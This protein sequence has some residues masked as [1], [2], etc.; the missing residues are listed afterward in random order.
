MHEEGRLGLVGL[1]HRLA[2]DDPKARA[3]SGFY[4]ALHSGVLM[5]WL[6]DPNAPHGRR[7]HRGRAA[8]GGSRP[9]RSRAI[10]VFVA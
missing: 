3:V 5:Q 10:R 6:V 8:S 9:V 7:T 1:F 2:R 4:Q